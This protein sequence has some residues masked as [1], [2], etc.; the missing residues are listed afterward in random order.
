MLF[1]QRNKTAARSFA[2]ALA[3]NGLPRT[4]VID[5]SGVNTAGLFEIN[6]MLKRF[7]CLVQ[8]EMIRIKCLNNM[9]EQDHRCI[10]KQ[11]R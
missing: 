10:K 2:H 3:V 6:H 8:I 4:I 1:K 9:V 5:K 7:G 11:I